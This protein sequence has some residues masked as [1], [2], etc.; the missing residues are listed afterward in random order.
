ML[1]RLRIKH[2]I[3]IDELE[4]DFGQGFNVFTGETGA[5]KS[6]LLGA[7]RLTLGE[8]AQGQLIREGEQKAVIQSVFQLSP[9]RVDLIQP[10]LSE[11]LDDQL[12]MTRELLQSGKSISKING[13]IT[14]LQVM[15]QV[16][17]VLMDIHGQ[18]DQ[19]ALLSNESQRILLDTYIG[20]AHEAD[21]LKLKH[22]YQ[23][24]KTIENELKALDDDP[25]AI[26][27]Q[28]E[29]VQF[30]MEDIDQVELMPADAMLDQKYDQLTH[31]Q[32]LIE[33]LDRSMQTIQS[34]GL[35]VSPI[36]SLL[37]QVI[38]DMHQASKHMPQM[39]TLAEQLVDMEYTLKDLVSTLESEREAL[40]IDPYELME[41]E[42]RLD[43][44]NQLKKKYGHD[45]EA[46]EAYRASLDHQ[47]KD[48][49]QLSMRKDRLEK[50]HLVQL[51]AYR[52]LAQKISLKR[53]EVAKDMADRIQHAL[54]T[55]NF[56][57]A[58]MHIKVNKAP[59]GPYGNDLVQFEVALNKGMAMAPLKQVAS[60]GEI[61]RI[62]LAIKTVSASLEKGKTLVFDEV[63]S[64]ISGETASIVAEALYK[65]SRSHQVICITHLS[66]VALYGDQHFLIRKQHTDE[67]TIS[68]VSLLKPLER[69]KE[70]ARILGGK[71]VTDETIEHAKAL[72]DL[73]TQRKTELE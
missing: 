1:Q 68:G 18:N 13:E 23:D 26:M 7:L 49:N 15:R 47:L 24:L 51:E 9:D 37:S 53:T 72:M 55:L 30:Q 17:E 31:A 22:L 63:D 21:V 11:P 46:I 54:Q 66:Q 50:N 45:I 42:K 56:D 20:E 19:Q 36:L 41:I 62:M 35:E 67:Q 14:S 70:I 59:D 27:R 39:R 44:I 57:G 2:Y 12:V 8:R 4:I 34:D 61:S 38:H 40:F 33:L 10:L 58:L 6:I 64:G 25:Q 60:G 43:R 73:T 65:V 71:H 5:G 69:Q 29:M 48:L 32:G 28:I 3:L 52:D 16:A